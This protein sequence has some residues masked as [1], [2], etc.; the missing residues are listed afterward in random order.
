MSERPFDVIGYYRAQAQSNGLAATVT[1]P[2]EYV[3]EAELKAIIAFLARAEPDTSVRRLL[4]IGCGNGHLASVIHR[5]FETRFDY[6]GIDYTQE[7][8]DLAKSRSLPFRFEYASVLSLPLENS[9][10]DLVVSDRVLINLLEPKDQA[11]AFTELARVTRRGGLLMLIEGFKQ[12]LENLNLARSE[13]MMPPIP[14]PPV[15]NWFTEER[16]A[17][18]IA[19][20]FTELSE[21]ELIGL[22]PQNLFS[23]H[24]FLT[25]FVHD[26]IRPGGG[27]TRNT[28]FAK[29]FARALPPVGDYSPLR[30]KYLRRI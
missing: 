5:R 30:L 14:E 25:R 22:A 16:W 19:D 17:A 18:A 11:A 12:G 3:V 7:M 21:E 1:M 28:Q 10:T 15:N 13:F 2:D 4:E 27:K 9:E 29:F 23:S 8:I 20:K 26:A 24:Y 6:T